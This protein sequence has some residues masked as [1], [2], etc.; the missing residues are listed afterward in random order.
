MPIAISTSRATITTRAEMMKPWS[1]GRIPAFFMLE[2]EVFNPI[3]DR[4]QT[5]RNLLTR[6]VVDTIVVGTGKTLATIDMARKPRMNQ[7]KI[8]LIEK[9]ALSSALFC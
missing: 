1:M 5:I 4:A 6:F 7:G 9:S 8:F 3:A 2:K